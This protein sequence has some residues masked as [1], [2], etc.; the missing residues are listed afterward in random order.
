[1]QPR[2]RGPPAVALDIPGMVREGR[3]L[4]VPDTTGWTE[5][6]DLIGPLAERTLRNS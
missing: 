1:M 3:A 2:D 4:T 6:V 5:P